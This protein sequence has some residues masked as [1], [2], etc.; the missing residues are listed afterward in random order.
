LQSA[1]AQNADVVIIDTAGRLHNKSKFVGEL[2][3]VRLCKGSYRGS[4]RRTFGS[5]WLYRS[6]CL[7]NKLNNLP[8]FTR[9]A[10]VFTK[11]DGTAGS[12]WNFKIN[13]NPV[14][15]IGVGEGI[16]STGFNKFIR[17]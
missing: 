7:L 6:K 17:R 13:L 14:K 1:V 15:Y 12:N 9:V 16:E 8:H 3:K 2:T 10:T 11:L 4:A 5:R